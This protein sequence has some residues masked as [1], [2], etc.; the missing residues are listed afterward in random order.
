[1]LPSNIRSSYVRVSELILYDG[2]REALIGAKDQ[3]ESQTLTEV[4]LINVLGSCWY[5]TQTLKR[6]KVRLNARLWTKFCAGQI[7]ILMV[8]FDPRTPS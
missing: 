7:K 4:R 6:L 8:R 2:Q 3:R 1:M 5:G